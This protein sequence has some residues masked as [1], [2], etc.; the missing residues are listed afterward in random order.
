MVQHMHDVL[1]MAGT[2]IVGGLAIRLHKAMPA[3]QLIPAGWASLLLGWIIALAMTTK[4][5]F[6]HPV[7][8]AIGIGLLLVGV[9]LLAPI[10]ST[11]L[12]EH[13][14]PRI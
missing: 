1:V 3:R 8:A 14:K 2:A 10:V 12:R 13:R 11:M 7:G 6:P 4:G 9:L 5:P